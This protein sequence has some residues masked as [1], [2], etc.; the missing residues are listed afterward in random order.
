LLC[1]VK[2]LFGIYREFPFDLAVL[3]RNLRMVRYVSILSW[4]AKLHSIHAEIMSKKRQKIEQAD[5]QGL[6]YFKLI[7]KLLESLHDVGT[8][9]D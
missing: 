4:I 2:K 9:R 3:A 6:K 5:I 7:H 8:E 1:E